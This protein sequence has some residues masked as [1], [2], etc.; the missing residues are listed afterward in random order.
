MET[1]D[2]AKAE[3]AGVETIVEED[4]GAR[5]VTQAEMAN[6]GAPGVTDFRGASRR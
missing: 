2:G 4:T 6:P 3:V 1:L 5:P